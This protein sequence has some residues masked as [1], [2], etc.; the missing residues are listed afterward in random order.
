M[1]G[2]SNQT[3]SAR[4]GHEPGAADA[5][6][7]DLRR[8][9]ADTSINQETLLATDYLNHFNEVIMLLELVPVDPECFEEVRGWTPKSYPDHFRDSG[10]AHRDLAI[11]AYYRSPDAYRKPFDATVA[12]LNEQ[13][14]GAI[15]SA[16]RLIEA[17]DQAALETT[18]AD[19]STRLRELIDLASGIIHGEQNAM[20]QAAIDRLIAGE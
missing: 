5:Y 14:A 10:F 17:D 15:E 16:T 3:E 6:L 11:A 20:N 2:F 8:R 18:I 12:E 19:C 1:A 9:L 13:V 4:E 7:A